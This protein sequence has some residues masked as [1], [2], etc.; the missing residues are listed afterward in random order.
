MGFYELAIGQYFADRPKASE[1]LDNALALDPAMAP[2]HYTRALLEI[3]EGKPVAAIND[4]RFA[5]EREP[6]NYRVLVRLGQAYL[7]ANRT[8]EAEE[9][10]K[11]ALDL[12]PDQPLGL[13]YYHRALAKLGRK[14][15][16]ESVLTRLKHADSMA[17]GRRPQSGLVDYLSLPPVEQ[18]ARYL[19][20]LR[21]NSEAYPTDPRWKI[22]LGKELFSDGEAAEGRRIF[23]S[24]QAQLSDPGLLAICGRILLDFDQFDLARP[25]LEQ[26][27]TAEPSASSVRIDLATAL[28]HLEGPQAA[29]SKLDGTPTENWTGDFYLLQAQILDSL[30]KTQ[31]AADALNRGIRAAPTQPVLYMQA[32]GFLLK[33]KLYHEALDLLEQAS[34]ILP[35]ARELQLAQVVTLYLLRRED[36]TQALLA[37]IQARW[38]EWDRPYLL[39]GVLLEIQTK[40]VEARQML[41]TAIALGANTP[42]AYYY[43]ALAITHSS[44]DDLKAAQN[45]IQRALD[46]TSKDPYIFLLAGQIAV[47]Q[48]D[49]PG[50][51]R[52]LLE[53]TKLDA[54]LI[55]AHY[56]LRDAYKALGDDQKSASELEVIKRLARDNP[57][58]EKN[59]FS[60][61]DFLFGVRPAH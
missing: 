34:R 45:A 36:D 13:I 10:L 26:A 6:K 24:L 55:P 52:R 27:M 50:A 35:N 48:Q 4:L 18:R 1:A 8:I 22:R 9:V 17:E 58:D 51:I 38:P 40:S 12:S 56:A 29:L 31:E 53:A 57:P 61:L 3:E 47:A 11:R 19:A 7:D 39:G 14:S 20:N 33:N 30:G 42:E 43:D 21:K 54:T 37:R 25:F 23:T 46:L 16:A 41:E 49:Y 32:A 5:L 15:E 2:A 59:P 60:T 44:P 28:F